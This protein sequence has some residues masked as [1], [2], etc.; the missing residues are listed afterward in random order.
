MITGGVKH[1]A[2]AGLTEFAGKDSTYVEGGALRVRVSVTVETPPPTLEITVVV[3]P[4][5]GDVTVLVTV[6]AAGPLPTTVV[7]TVPGTQEDPVDPGL[8]GV[9]LEGSR[10]IVLVAGD[11]TETTGHELSPLPG[12]VVVITLI[13]VTVGPVHPPVTPPTVV[14]ELDAVQSLQTVVA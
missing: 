9:Q 7:V 2:R 6:F 12:R 1:K 10:V 5:P 8:T 4:V 11:G 3:N 13:L 14:V